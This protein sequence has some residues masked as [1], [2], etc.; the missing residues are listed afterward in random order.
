M[1]TL[2][3]WPPAWERA[4]MVTFTYNSSTGEVEAVGTEK[5][6]F[7]FSYCDNHLE[8]SSSQD[9]NS[10]EKTVLVRDCLYQAGL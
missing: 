4:G 8:L 9:L 3:V 1:G 2:L 5:F 6:K 10:P 7:L